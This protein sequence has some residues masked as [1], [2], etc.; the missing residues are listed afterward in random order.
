ML[1]LKREWQNTPSF[2][3]ELPSAESEESID[4]HVRSMLGSPESFPFT[5]DENKPW[6]LA[7]LLFGSGL[8]QPRNVRFLGIP[9][10]SDPGAALK[11]LLLEEW[12]DSGRDSWPVVCGAMVEPGNALSCET[13]SFF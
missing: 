1:S 10:L 5:P 2:R 12:Y 11:F 7:R 4:N 6:I 9:E 8:L 3:T 13:A